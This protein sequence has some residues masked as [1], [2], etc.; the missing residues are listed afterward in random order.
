M[1][2]ATMAMVFVAGCSGAGTGSTKDGATSQN[3]DTE[4]N[5]TT[6]QTG[7][8]QTGT[9]PSCKSWLVSYKLDGSVFS[10]DSQISKDFTVAAPYDADDH[11]GPGT[12]VLRMPDVGGAPGAG[13]VQ[14]NE[15]QFTLNFTI[16]AAGLAN[17]TTAI[18]NQA[19]PEDCGLTS[20]T[21]D[22]GTLT[23]APP[24]IN[25]CQDGQISCV[26]AVCGQF[27]SPPADQPEVID[28]ECSDWQINSFTFSD[29]LK[30]FDMAAA[31]V[32]DESGS[33]TT[34]AFHGQVTSATLD[35]NPPAC[36]CGG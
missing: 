29:D 18:E 16:G 11:T 6:G 3:S 30:T 22:A 31:T 32:T 23:W 35:P 12:I 7:D 19:G 1:K 15:Y 13:E 9:D 8:T 14:W 20:G 27:G 33:T 4:T 24:T 36:A 26:G 5:D 21:L 2:R 17:V 10:V 34:L 28:N 25:N